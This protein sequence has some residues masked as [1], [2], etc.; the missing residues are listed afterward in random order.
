ML[1]ICRPQPFETLPTPATP[2]A[3]TSKISCTFRTDIAGT[4]ERQT[5]CCRLLG[6]LSE[7]GDAPRVPRVPRAACEACEFR[8]VESLFDRRPVLASLAVEHVAA[9]D[10]RTASVAQ[11][12]EASLCGQVLRSRLHAVV[13]CDVVVRCAADDPPLERCLQ[14][15]LAQDR[16]HST[17]HLFG[18]VPRQWRERAEADS[19]VC[20]LE[21]DADEFGWTVA[22][23]EVPRFASDL[24]AVV[25]PGFVARANEISRAAERLVRHGY[26]YTTLRRD[27]ESG[28]RDDSDA[29]FERRFAAAGLARR[30]ALAELADV[31]LED[32]ASLCRWVRDWHRDDADRAARSPSAIAGGDRATPPRC[33]VVLP[34][35]GHLGFVDESLRAL[36]AQDGATA[37]VHLV[38]DATVESTDAFLAQWAAHPQVRT[39]RNETNI[40]QFASFNAVSRFFETPYAAVQDADDLSLPHRLAWSVAFLDRSGADLFAAAVEL[41]GAAAAY[42]PTS[43]DCREFAEQ[44]VPRRRFSRYPPL[45][46]VRYF[47]ENPTLVMRVEAFRQLGGFADFGDPLSNRASLDT[48]FQCRAL[49][50]GMRWAISREVVLRYRVH[51]AS[52]TANAETGW[53]SAARSKSTRLVDEY[54]RRQESGAFDARAFGSL[55]RDA[56]VTR[57]LG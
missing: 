26:E 15:L 12:A 32:A 17:L 30:A 29:A 28:K 46:R 4:G 44:P 34:F 9:V 33:D 53:G 37:I 45:D 6:G 38:D 14:A 51:E 50:A 56:G 5:A 52:A 48:E 49:L 3:M 1:V 25:E 35:R 19:R 2:S 57:R 43:D 40:G 47:A 42:Q 23:R 41:F 36:L 24:V 18:A 16:V 31:P 10:D 21:A 39:Y 7:S 20:V 22:R 27:D 54:R 13:G 11:V 55:H 8:T